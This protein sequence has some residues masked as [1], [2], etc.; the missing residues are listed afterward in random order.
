MPRKQVCRYCQKEFVPE[1]GKPGYIDECPEC[2][3]A[4]REKLT[5]KTP[6]R[7]QPG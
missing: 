2:L 5:P 3:N 7:K 4:Q 1:P 6:K